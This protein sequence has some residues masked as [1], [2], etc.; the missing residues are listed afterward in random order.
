MR[1]H[2]TLQHSFLTA[3]LLLVASALLLVNPSLAQDPDCATPGKSPETNGASW[4]PGANVTVIIN[5]DDFPTAAEQ[6]AIQQAFTTWQSA[7]TNSGVTFTFTTGL[8]P[9]Y[10]NNSYYIHRG[11][12]NT[13]GSTGTSWTGG[14]NTEGNVTTYAHTVLDTVITRTATL[15]NMML[16][17]IGHTFGLDDCVDC[18]QGSTIMSAYV[19]DCYCPT[20]P[21]DQEVPW[22]GIRWGCPPLQAP[23]EC[24]E[25]AV[26]EYAHYAN[27]DSTTEG[28]CRA[29][30][31]N[32]DPNTCTCGHATGCDPS[33]Q[34][35][36]SDCETAG[37]IWDSS[38]CYCAYDHNY[39]YPDGGGYCWSDCTD[40][41][42]C[43]SYNDQ[44]ECQYQGTDC[45]SKGCWYNY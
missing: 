19:S 2:P 7:H 28:D 12:T 30:N 37:G 16:H 32:W 34:S 39:Y 15:T 17:E 4:A 27:C 6:Q 36:A 24:D 21:C 26:R 11:S 35:R 33:D 8:D 5:P 9:G 29:S 23:R 25:S 13:G 41:Y 42:S 14:P 22:N 1:S 45:S 20:F 38:S 31:G 10:A 40:Y 43:A 18:P 3:F 44:T